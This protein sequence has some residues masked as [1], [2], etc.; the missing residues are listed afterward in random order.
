MQL[1]VTLLGI[2]F[3][4]HISSMK[5]F[6]LIWR[7]IISYRKSQVPYKSNMYLCSMVMVQRIIIL[8]VVP[9]SLHFCLIFWNGK[10][11]SCVINMHYIKYQEPIYYTIVKSAM[12]HGATNN[13]YR[14]TKT[15]LFYALVFLPLPSWCLMSWHVMSEKGLTQTCDYRYNH[16]TVICYFIT[17]Y[18]LQQPSVSWQF[19]T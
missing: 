14:N 17:Y 18:K 3:Y 11:P 6:T 8:Y 12:E 4:L 1:T 2:I 9:T 7:L 19:K 16:L 5:W 10:L 13:M 15:R